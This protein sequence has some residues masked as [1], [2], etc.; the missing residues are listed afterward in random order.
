[1]PGITIDMR[2]DRA[3]CFVI[4]LHRPI[5]HHRCDPL[6]ELQA[7][8]AIAD[9][10]KSQTRKSRAE[11]RRNVEQIVVALDDGAVFAKADGILTSGFDAKTGEFFAE[12]QSAFLS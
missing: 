9:P 10:E 7:Q 4:Q 6:L 8:N 11:V 2:L 5:A 1:M 3:H 12:S